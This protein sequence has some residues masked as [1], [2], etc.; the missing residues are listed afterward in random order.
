MMQ[1]GIPI[2][3]SNV[4]GLKELFTDKKSA[5]M[6]S[7]HTRLDGLLGLEIRT[8]ELCHAIRQLLEDKPLAKRLGLNAHNNWKNRYTSAHMGQATIKVY[9]KLQNM[10]IGVSNTEQYNY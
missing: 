6:V 8:E 4:P 2:V 3:C 5:L 9:Q 1:Y 10:N 7:L